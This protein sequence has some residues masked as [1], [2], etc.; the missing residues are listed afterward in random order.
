MLPP[1][2]RDTGWFGSSPGAWGSI[3]FLE[4]QAGMSFL[5]QQGVPELRSAPGSSH[6]DSALKAVKRAPLG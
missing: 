1:Q 5:L 2:G 6:L 4:N 3:D